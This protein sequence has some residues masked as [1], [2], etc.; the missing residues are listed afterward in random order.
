MAG[1]R[2]D[3][4][5]VSPVVQYSEYIHPLR[6]EPRGCIMLLVKSTFYKV[7]EQ[8]SLEVRDTYLIN[9]SCQL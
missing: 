2:L 1:D 7:F 8:F 4:V 6:A 9:R 3:I 5:L